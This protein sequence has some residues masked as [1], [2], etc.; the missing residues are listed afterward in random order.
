MPLEASLFHWLPDF[1]ASPLKI[2]RV[3]F[4]PKIINLSV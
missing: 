4:Y 2:G 3:L 1:S